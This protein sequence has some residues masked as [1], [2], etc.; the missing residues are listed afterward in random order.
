[1]WAGAFGDPSPPKAKVSKPGG[2]WR[3]LVGGEGQKQR[4][5]PLTLI[6]SWILREEQRPPP[7]GP[8][9]PDKCR[10]PGVMPP[11][12][13]L[14][15][16][17]QAM[18]RSPVRDSW[19]SQTTKG[20]RHRLLPQT[21]WAAQGQDQTCHLSL[22]PLK[23]RPG[24]PAPPPSSTVYTQDGGREVCRLTVSLSRDCTPQK[25]LVKP[26]D[27][28]DWVLLLSGCSVEAHSSAE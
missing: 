27:T 22:Y 20:S 7:P 9:G 16:H 23:G 11:R 17:P 25:S 26:G 14:T 10:F 8:Q 24:V 4:Q 21:H 3:C 18:L 13:E 5:G 19:A 6:P 12:Q 15:Q 1:M 28:G 2:S